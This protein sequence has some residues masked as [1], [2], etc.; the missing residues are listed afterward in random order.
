MLGLSARKPVSSKGAVVLE[1][2][3]RCGQ[4]EA[5]RA[6]NHIANMP[7]PVVV[8]FEAKNGQDGDKAQDHAR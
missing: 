4:A 7:D 8:D 3:W 5:A 1:Q 2:P 6:I